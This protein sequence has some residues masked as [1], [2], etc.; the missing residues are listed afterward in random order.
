GLRALRGG[1]GLPPTERGQALNHT[2]IWLRGRVFARPV[3]FPVFLEKLLAVGVG[4]IGKHLVEEIK[5]VLSDERGKIAERKVV[6]SMRLQHLLDSADNIG[7]GLQQGAVDVKQVGCEA[8]H[9]A[10]WGEP[11]SIRPGFCLGSFSGRSTCWV[12][13]SSSPP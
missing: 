9:Q 13:D 8:R 2:G 6:G 5:E 10:G 7:R 4:G 3:G 12:S 1:G 11:P